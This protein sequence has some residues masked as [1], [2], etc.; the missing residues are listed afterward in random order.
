MF[1]C[2]FVFLNGETIVP[3]YLMEDCID[4]QRIKT[5][6]NTKEKPPNIS[7]RK[8]WLSGVNKRCNEQ[9]RI[10]T[11]LINSVAM[12]HFD[13]LLK[14]SPTPISRL[15]SADPGTPVVSSPAPHPSI[16]TPQTN[17]GTASLCSAKKKKQSSSTQCST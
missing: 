13:V 15:S 6:T 5:K 7:I 14:C 3:V 16:S 12:Q 1:N 10:E 9:R 8:D 2:M 17:F 4:I 11:W